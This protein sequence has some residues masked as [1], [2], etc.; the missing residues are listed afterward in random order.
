MSSFGWG[1]SFFYHPTPKYN[2]W[3][4]FRPFIIDFDLELILIFESENRLVNTQCNIQWKT[5]NFASSGLELKTIKHRQIVSS[6][7]DFLFIVIFAYLAGHRLIVD[8]T[9]D[10]ARG[11]H[12]TV[13]ALNGEQ[14]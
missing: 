6:W 1:T 14:R 13:I 4:H 11:R 3:N 2:L 12:P 10:P 7:Q 9:C 5:N 8:W